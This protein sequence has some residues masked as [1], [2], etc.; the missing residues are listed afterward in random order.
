MSFGWF[1]VANGPIKMFFFQPWKGGKGVETTHPWT[2]YQP[3]SRFH[4]TNAHASIL[5]RTDGL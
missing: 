1:V 4:P 5:K 2:I 3:I